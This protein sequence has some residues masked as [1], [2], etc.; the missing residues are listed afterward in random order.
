MRKQRKSKY[1]GKEFANGWICTGIN[2][3]KASLAHK[4]GGPT[5][6]YAFE[7]TTSDGKFNKWVR[8][9]GQDASK[10]YKG[11]LTVDDVEAKKTTGVYKT[12]YYFIGEK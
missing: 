2:I 6:W 9:D 12:N 8:V 7:R 10:I 5:Y 3:N 1:I 4:N 11:L